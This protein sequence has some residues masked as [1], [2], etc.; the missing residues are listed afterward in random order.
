MLDFRTVDKQVQRREPV[1]PRS[2]VLSGS[3][4]QGGLCGSVG[5]IEMLLDEQAMHVILDGGVRRR[6]C[7]RQRQHTNTQRRKHP[8]TTRYFYFFP[9]LSQAQI[10]RR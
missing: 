1:A 3:G 9:N 2:E 10:C 4:V 5:S 6:H 7:Q 8:N